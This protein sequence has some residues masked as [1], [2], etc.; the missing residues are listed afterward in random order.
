M[1]DFRALYTIN[2]YI[3][4]SVLFTECELYFNELSAINILQESN[5]I[6]VFHHLGMT[7]QLHRSQLL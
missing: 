4:P 1:R 7:F 5:V 6:V 2:V 3:P